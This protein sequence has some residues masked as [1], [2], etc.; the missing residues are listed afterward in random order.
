[1]PVSEKA[2]EHFRQI[3]LASL[4]DAQERCV[5]AAAE[6]PGQKLMRALQ[7]SDEMIRAV[8]R[9]RGSLETL[10]RASEADIEGQACLAARW[11]RLHPGT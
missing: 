8:A 9:M 4:Q 1:M 2:R 5:E 6:E 10:T 3:A 7:L 11:R